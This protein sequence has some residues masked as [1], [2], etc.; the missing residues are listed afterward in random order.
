MSHATTTSR[1]YTAINIL[2]RMDRLGR[3]ERH[4]SRNASLNRKAALY[5]IT[6][7]QRRQLDAVIGDVREGESFQSRVHESLRRW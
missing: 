4:Y 3:W 1:Q 2:H 5:L 7:R 6:R